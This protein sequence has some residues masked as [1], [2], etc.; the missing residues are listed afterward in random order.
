[1]DTG[2][3]TG[4]DAVDDAVGDA[5]ARVLGEGGELDRGSLRRMTAD[6]TR[7]LTLADSGQLVIDPDSAKGIAKA[8]DDMVEE[9]Y[10][11]RVGLLTAGQRPQLG[12]G[13][14][15]GRVSAY[16]R[17]AADSFRDVIDELETVCRQCARAF[18]AA[19]DQYVA[20]E[21]ETART[22][23]RIEGTV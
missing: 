19:A 9:I 23:R 12:T 11:I 22:F 6:A 10:W 14:Y 15:A 16:Q 17:E 21:D 3:D 8:Y 7:L 1:M 18:R 20:Q 5:Q 2:T 13:P 4:T